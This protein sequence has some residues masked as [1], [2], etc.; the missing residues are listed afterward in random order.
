MKGREGKKG[1][2]R[3][4]ER[5]L[6]GKE[7]ERNGKG[8]GWDGTGWDGMGWGGMGKEGGEGRG[9]VFAITQFLLILVFHPTQSDSQF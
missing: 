6:K 1:R 3:E 4:K 5:E 7:W 9:R 2:G 8:M